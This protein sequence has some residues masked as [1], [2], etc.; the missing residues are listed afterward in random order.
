MFGPGISWQS[1]KVSA[2]SCSFIHAV[3]LDDDAAG[4][5]EAA[6]E[7]AQRRF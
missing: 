7:T 2:N 1:V 5:D 6:A 3:L 4:P